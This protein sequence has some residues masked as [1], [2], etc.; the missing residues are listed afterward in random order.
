MSGTSMSSP[1]AA[2]AI[3]LMLEANGDLTPAEAKQILM[4]T[5]RKPD[6]ASRQ[7]G[8]SGCIDIHA[9]VT[10]ALANSAVGN[11][12][13]D[14]SSDPV[15]RRT[16]DTVGIACRGVFRCTVTSL[17]GRVLSESEFEN[18][19]SITLPATRGVYVVTVFADGIGVRSYKMTV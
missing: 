8:S 13:A 7:W 6:N 18:T 1:Y 19:G 11:V 10:K 14:H 16:G 5:A 4:S 15:V 12:T 17:S 9:A 2:G 3:A